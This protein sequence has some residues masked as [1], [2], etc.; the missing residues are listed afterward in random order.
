MSA[1]VRAAALAE[2]IRG[3]E[4]RAAARLMRALDD[5]DPAAREVLAALYS[6]TGRAFLLGV[7]GNPGAGKSTLTDQLVGHYRGQGRRV[8]VV[9]VD[10]SSPF[11][12]GAILGD[13]IRMQRHAGDEGVFIR[14]LATR[15]VLGGLTAS[16]RD[17]VTVFDAMGFD[18]VIVETVGVGQ[19]EVDVVDLVHTSVVV[20]VP[21]LGDGVQAIKAGLLE[22]A[23]VF[24]INKADHP[25]AARAERHLAM[26]LDLEGR[27]RRGWAVPIQRTV[28]TGGEGIEALVGHVE[29]HRAW[30]AES[31]EGARRAR[32]RARAG[33]VDRVYA[34]LR[35]AA[36]DAI[37]GM[38]GIDGMIDDLQAGRGDPWHMADA[39]MAS[40]GLD[41]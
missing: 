9:A 11:T 18:V 6:Q 7:T 10:P 41:G 8:A 24:V 31:P 20:S 25:D 32:A 19:D 5:E 17:I 15:G 26:L 34:R 37:D 35:A 40:L 16:T 22:I 29:R 27:E 14:S 21:G 3:G 23:D 2:R 39:I 13:R 1:G 12:G 28:A 4:V 36:G 33:L 30:L 38:G